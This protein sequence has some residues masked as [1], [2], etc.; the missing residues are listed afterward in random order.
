M[1]FSFLCNSDPSALN[2]PLKLFNKALE[3]IYFAILFKDK[4]NTSL[5]GIVEALSYPK[6]IISNILL[7]LYETA[8]ISIGLKLVNSE[9][10]PHK[11]LANSVT[12]ISSFA[13]LRVLFLYWLRSSSYFGI[14]V[15]ES[16]KF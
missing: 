13:S 9:S 7:T 12:N 8:L 2:V 14:K 4:L 16:S 6:S 1:L 5:D 15:T 10:S 3:F 11:N